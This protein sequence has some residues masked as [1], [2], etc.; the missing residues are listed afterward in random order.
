MSEQIERGSNDRNKTLAL[1]KSIFTDTSLPAAERLKAAHHYLSVARLNKDNAPP[2][3][4][5]IKQFQDDPNPEVRERA[6]RL[7][8]RVMKL[9]DLKGIANAPIEPEIESDNADDQ[10]IV[11]VEP[12]LASTY[13]ATPESDDT[14]A[15]EFPPRNLMWPPDASV[16][17]PGWIDT[18]LAT[19]RLIAG[20]AR[21]MSPAPSR[22]DVCETVIKLALGPNYAFA[23]ITLDMC[24]KLWFALQGYEPRPEDPRMPGHRHRF[25]VFEK[26][27][28]AVYYLATK[29]FGWDSLLDAPPSVSY[30]RDLLQQA[31]ESTYVRL[32]ALNSFQRFSAAFCEADQLPALI[33]S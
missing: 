16:Y 32:E 24:Q 25:W 6:L 19:Q 20:G 17:V 4:K 2:L 30:V 12:T 8:K 15:V 11:D 22:P 21:D 26:L 18:K 10:S 9:R 29:K 23:D 28:A 13:Q 3:N 1:K 14:F 7:K 27:H 31:S 33:L 5:L